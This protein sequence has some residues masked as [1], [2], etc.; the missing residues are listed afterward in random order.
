MP[1][2]ILR[3]TPATFA[4]A[5]TL[6]SASAHA[7]NP[8]FSSSSFAVGTT[9]VY[10]AVADFNGDGRPDIAV[11]NQGSANITI[12]L[13]KAGGGYTSS[14]VTVAG[15]ITSIVAADLNG[16]GKVDLAIGNPGPSSGNITYFVNDG[17][18]NFTATPMS[19]VL[20]ASPKFV[21]APDMNADGYADLV[22]SDGSAALTRMGSTITI[23]GLF[24]G[25]NPMGSA[26]YGINP[27]SPS[28]YPG[29]PAGGFMAVGDVNN[30]GEVDVVVV[31]NKNDIVT[32]AG[33]GLGA[34]IAS[35]WS[36][37]PTGTQSKFVALAD[38]NRDGNLDAIVTCNDGNVYVMLG[39]GTGAFTL[40]GTGTAFGGTS[41]SGV[42]AGDFNGDGFLDLAVTSSASNSV[43]ILL[44]NG[45]GT[46]A[47]PAALVLSLGVAGTGGTV[48]AKDVNGDGKIDLLVTDK[49]NGQVYVFL[50]NLPSI[51]APTLLSFHS[52]TGAAAPPGQTAPLTFTSGTAPGFNAAS[53]A[54]WLSAVV[55]GASP[56]TS[57]TIQVDPTKVTPGSYNG[58]L[59]LTATG[60]FGTAIQ[61][62]LTVATPSGTLIAGTVMN[63]GGLTSSMAIADMNN[64]GIPDLVVAAGTSI[65]SMR[66]NG[67]G[68]FTNKANIGVARNL[69][70]VAIA[71]FNGDGNPDVATS[72]ANFSSSVTQVYTMLGDGN[73]SLS[74]SAQLVGIG[75]FLPTATVAGDFNGDGKMDIAVLNSAKVVG[76]DNTST[77]LVLLGNGANAFVPYSEIPRDLSGMKGAAMVVGDFNRDG[78]LDLAIVHQQASASN[79]T[80]GAI[81]ILLGNG[82][83]SFTEAAGSPYLTGNTSTSVAIGDFNNDGFTDLAV[84]AQADAT[85]SI[86]VLLGNGA[87]GFNS[88]SVAVTGQVQGL[89]AADFDGDGNVDL[90]AV[91]VTGN[92]DLILFGNGAG[93]FVSP[94]S[95]P[96]TA[97]SGAAGYAVAADLTG[98]GLTDLVSTGGFSQQLNFFAGSK[99]PT[100]TTLTSPVSGREAV[101]QVTFTSS[102]VDSL[103][104]AKPTGAVT[105][106]DGA[107][108]YPA[109]AVNASGQASTGIA[110]SLGAY[111]FYAS[112]SGDSRTSPSDSS[113]LKTGITAFT[114]T[115]SFSATPSGKAGGK[116]T[117]FNVS[118]IDPQT[119]SVSTTYT[120]AI[121]LTLNTGSFDASSTTMANAVSGVAAF[122]NLIVDTPGTYTITATTTGATSAN[123]NSFTVGAAG[124]KCD[125]NVDGT[126]NVA[127][128]QLII[129]E[130]LG[131]SAANNDL[132]SDHVVNVADVQIV[133][134][135]ALGLG[136]AAV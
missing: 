121:T 126:V 120:S 39:N 83:G 128:V 19:P 25:F 31:T 5:I 68:V 62:K 65:Y 98:D 89:T 72:A 35:W 108:N 117:S 32:M 23:G 93:G 103:A 7:A 8:S 119:S 95:L 102:T 33:N 12:L 48:V 40:Q 135:A 88:S 45:T 86:T 16:D 80:Q 37:L 110:V 27:S 60:Y 134:N 11:A 6:F 29:T 105:F 91:N 56:P 75:G 82:D 67:A 36:A 41:A 3:S 132:N 21:I 52:M 10:L 57:L 116:L 51:A 22:W 100:T 74:A 44:G 24:S 43:Y 61:V 118:V 70:G 104:W 97:T 130:A 99:A 76:S 47:T 96:A 136:C 53:N 71:D 42:A 38:V 46:F 54:T 59:T 90:A 133:I 18:G 114:P 125:V 50:N 127:D 87:G 13:A 81:T 15:G 101:G 129:N 17:A 94:F 1:K 115:L 107:N 112:Y 49:T 66:N 28:A 30:N 69:A 85:H 124:N 14:T 78:K 113:A 55:N 109:G 122:S 64:D 73:S 106:I 77:L 92:T 63:F 9:P 123:G 4:L 26:G 20:N 58:T 34:L 84:G 79:L 131:V 2:S 111:S